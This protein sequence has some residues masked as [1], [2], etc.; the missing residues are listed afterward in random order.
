MA[1]EYKSPPIGQEI[2]CVMKNISVEI[3]LNENK[4]KKLLELALTKEKFTILKKIYRSFS[5]KGFTALILLAESHLAMH[6]YPE[7]NALYINM[8]SCRGPKDAESV[9]DFLKQKLNPKK[10]LFFKKGEVPIKN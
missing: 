3:L 7:Y 5:P 8:Y 6:T 4:L 9:F 2:S 1:I 10:I